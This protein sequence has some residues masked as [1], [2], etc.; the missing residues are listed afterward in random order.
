[1]GVHDLKDVQSGRDDDAEV[2]VAAV[3]VAQVADE[4]RR[5]AAVESAGRAVGVGVRILFQSLSSR[6]A[7]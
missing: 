3:V 5:V 1:M 2:A 6:Y 4:V 7:F